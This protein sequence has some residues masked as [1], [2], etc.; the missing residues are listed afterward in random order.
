MGNMNPNSSRSSASPNNGRTN[1]NRGGM[2]NRNSMS[3]PT[4]NHLHVMELM[5]A[6]EDS[7]QDFLSGDASPDLA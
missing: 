1:M 7:D 4:M 5:N 3:P 6:E 2:N